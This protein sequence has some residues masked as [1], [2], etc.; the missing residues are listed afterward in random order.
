MQSNDVVMSDASSTENTAPNSTIYIHNLNEK[1]KVP[2][3]V[4]A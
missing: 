1:V 3:N 2:G 4:D